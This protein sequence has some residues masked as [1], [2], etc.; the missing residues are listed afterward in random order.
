MARRTTERSSATISSEPFWPPISPASFS[1]VTSAV[2]IASF[3]SCSDTG[4]TP[5]IPCL[6]RAHDEPDRDANQRHLQVGK[7]D[8]TNQ[9]VWPET[10]QRQHRQKEREAEGRQHM[11]GSSHTITEPGRCGTDQ[12]LDR[13]SAQPDSQENGDRTCQP[14]GK[15]T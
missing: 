5:F 4:F 13:A 7:K 6:S 15:L 10:S 3:S 11:A 14:P 1:G 9:E 12:R 2:W 8:K